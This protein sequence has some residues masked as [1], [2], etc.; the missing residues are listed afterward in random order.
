MHHSE[1]A[2][3]HAATAFHVPSGLTQRV[4]DSQ[5]TAVVP[6]TCDEGEGGGP[7]LWRY[8]FGGDCILYVNNIRRS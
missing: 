3:E 6:A 2:S 7:T 4:G 5:Q 8:T 1:H